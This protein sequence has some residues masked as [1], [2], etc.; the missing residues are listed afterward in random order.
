MIMNTMCI[1]RGNVVDHSMVEVGLRVPIYKD[2]EITAG[3]SGSVPEI[4]PLPYSIKFVCELCGDSGIFDQD[5]KAL[6][7]HQ[8]TTVM[9]GR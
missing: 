9:T 8:P 6:E 5:G 1:R 7:Y 3:G 4:I 2:V